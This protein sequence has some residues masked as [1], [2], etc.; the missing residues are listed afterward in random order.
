MQTLPPTTT[1]PLAES[2]S[3]T[4]FAFL[5]GFAA[6][7]RAGPPL[8][9]ASVA[10]LLVA[11]TAILVL[12]AFTV[13]QALA[14]LLSGVPSPMAGV[15][16]LQC[17]GLLLAKLV[18]DAAQARLLAKAVAG[19]M[20]SL[21]ERMFSHLQDLPAIH[22][23]DAHFGGDTTA[24]F[25]TGVQTVG[26]FLAQT[27]PKLA[28]NLLLAAGSVAAMAALDWRLTLVCSGALLLTL[29]IP[30][31]FSR[32]VRLILRQGSGQDARTLA[33]VEEVLVMHAPMR[34]FNIAGPWRARYQAALAAVALTQLRRVGMQRLFEGSMVNLANFLVFVLIVAA[35][36]LSSYGSI[37][38]DVLGAFFVLLQ[39]VAGVVSRMGA[40]LG[41]T[42]PA[43]HAARQIEEF[44]ARPT[45]PSTA[46]PLSPD[47]GFGDGLRFE[48]VSFAFEGGHTILDRVSFHVRPGES[49]ALVGS[50]GSGKSSVLALL[51][52]EH[53]PQ[54]G[55]VRIGGRDVADIDHVAFCRMV[56]IISQDTRLF[57]LSVRE[58][59]RSG[60]LDAT[61]AQVQDAARQAEAHAM[62]LALP[63]GYDTQVVEY[64]AN[65]SGGQRQRIAIAR[66]LVARPS[67]LL[68]DEATSALDAETEG[69]I[70]ASLA[71]IAQT[72]TTIQVTHRLRSVRH[73]SRIHVMEGGRIV[74]SGTH[75]SLLMQGGAYARMLEKQRAVEFEGKRPRV[76]SALLRNVRLFAD[77]GD[78]VLAEM[79]RCLMVERVGQDTV[80]FEEG[81]EGDKFYVV[82]RGTLEVQRQG[83]TLAFLDDGDCFGEIALLADLPRNGTVLTRTECVLLTLDR[84]QFRAIVGQDTVLQAQLDALVAARSHR[85]SESA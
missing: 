25:T 53:T 82:A 33:L 4:G 43:E 26:E 79:S 44:L 35:M 46:D 81:S 30:R 28:Q 61:D 39:Y 7:H 67:L 54:Q 75:A 63:Q 59:I 31:I 57:N 5:L 40:L 55:R 48:E 27:A 9:L 29:P 85:G 24:L 52:R 34:A 32:K 41:K 65:L 8:V 1:R 58:N 14:A 70:N 6:R 77:V 73:A 84:H 18:V 21:R 38:I 69:A 83:R 62:V 15:I 72:C 78:A 10:A 47:A 22:Y 20:Q 12:V 19:T 11:D 60:R 68:I 49:L 56:A 76:D 71:R 50:S 17:V 13:K 74:E 23:G 36:V 3:G 80:L 2:T 42:G 64:G 66:A 16:A 45:P 51:M 37:A